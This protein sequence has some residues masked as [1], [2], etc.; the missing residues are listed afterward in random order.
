MGLEDLVSAAEIL[1][2][3]VSDVLI[4][5][6]G[7][8][9]LSASLDE[10]IRQKRLENH[11]KLLGFVPD[12]DLPLA[13]RAADLSVVPTVALE[14]FGLV[15]VESLAAGTPA[16]VTPVAG[17]P[18]VVWALSDKL[19]LPQSGPNAIAI[20]IAG[21]LSNPSALPDAEECQTYAR[22]Q[23]DWRHAAN[24]IAD[25]YRDTVRQRR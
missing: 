17:L 13:Y 7:K 18:E 2:R 4:V 6:A 8:G 23:F 5:I 22:T 16:L 15:A 11:V 24:K 1:R 12:E 14:G 9:P 10:Q 21:A 3:K 25:L 19:V 20:G